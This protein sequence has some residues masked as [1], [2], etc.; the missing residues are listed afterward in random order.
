M[1]L[2]D[3]KLLDINKTVGDYLP[4]DDSASI[5]HLRIADVLTH[6]AGLKPFFEFYRPTLTSTKYQIYYRRVPSDT[7]PIIVCDSLCLRRDYPDSMW[8]TMSHSYIKPDAGYVYSDVDFYILQKIVEQIT[9]GPLDRYVSETFYRPM[10]LTRIGYMPSTRFARSRIVPT[11]RDTSFRHQ[12]VQGYVHDPGSAMYGGVAGHAGVFSNALDLAQVMQLLLNGGTYNGIRFMSAET[13]ALFTRQ[14]NPRSRRGL[15]FDK[16]E[17]DA[18][19]PSPTC[20]NVPP[21]TFGHTG[22]TG[23]S[24]WS[25]PDN[26]LTFIFLSNRGYPDAENPKLV[27]MNIRT[28]LQRI[29]YKAIGKVK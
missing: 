10:G 16:P 29:V 9:S 21:S 22:F 8:H 28:D 2:V 5:K 27:K 1:K 11:E 26:D 17:P 25:D 14:Y 23:T 7:F 18:H 4:L 13:V 3:R 24:V 6:Q 12:L 15:G 20:E 19:K